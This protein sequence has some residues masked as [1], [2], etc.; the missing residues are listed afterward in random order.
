MSRLYDL[1]TILHDMLY[2]T[3]PRIAG[4]LNGDYKLSLE[5]YINL[6]P[7]DASEDI[8]KVIGFMLESLKYLNVDMICTALKPNDV[9][10]KKYVT[11]MLGSKINF[12]ISLL[13]PIFN[14]I[15]CIASSPANTLGTW[16]K[17]QTTDEIDF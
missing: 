3:F 6:I 2:D 8:N 15:D 14:A 13:D 7:S 5:K 4:R 11:N 1:I 9:D 17:K 16:L 12:S 10:S